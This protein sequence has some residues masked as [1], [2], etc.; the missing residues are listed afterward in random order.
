MRKKHRTKKSI[1][2]FDNQHG[3]LDVYF[4]AHTV[5]A[6]SPEEYRSERHAREPEHALIFH[7]SIN[8]RQ[9][10]LFG[11]YICA[12]LEGTEYITKEIGLFHREGHPEELRL[13]KH[14]VKNSAFEL[15]TIGDF[16]RR[17]S[18]ST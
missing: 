14:F 10:L 3:R 4:R 11:A 17:F 1:K 13:L 6:K 16:R 18:S 9:E 12:E 7:C 2:E 8:A 15:G 5:P